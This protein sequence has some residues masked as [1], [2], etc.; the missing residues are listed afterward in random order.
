METGIIDARLS[1]DVN[2]TLT[3]KKLIEK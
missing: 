2:W 3:R 1:G